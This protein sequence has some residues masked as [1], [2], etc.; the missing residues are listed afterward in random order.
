MNRE[1]AVGVQ[2]APA[3]ATLHAKGLDMKLAATVSFAFLLGSVSLTAQ[4]P[5]QP[6][7]PATDL[8]VQKS[9][10]TCPVKLRAQHGADGTMR[11]VDKTRPEGVAQRLHLIVASSVSKRIVEARLRVHGVSPKG[12]VSHADTTHITTDIARNLTVR[13]TQSGD[14]EAIGDA[15]VP[16]MS[17]VLEVELHSVKLADGK[18]LR[19][20]AADGCRF[21]PEH[22]MLVADR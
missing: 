21:T 10:A 12:R 20:G 17:A 15:W 13:F 4:T 1:Y 22:L 11:Q 3:S 9:N 2:R 6:K 8:S 19:F 14:N 7:S 18:I 16:G 5:S